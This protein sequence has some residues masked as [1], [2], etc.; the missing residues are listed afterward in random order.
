[1]ILKSPL[2]LLVQIMLLVVLAGAAQG[3]PIDRLQAFYKDVRTLRGDFTQ[4]VYDAHMKVKQRA[5]GTFAIR[6]PDRFHWAY[7][8]P[9]QQ[10]IVSDGTK[11]WIYDSDLQ[12]VTVKKLDEAL[13]STPAQLLSNSAALE[14]NFT[15]VDAGTAED[16]QWVALAPRDKDSGFERIRLGFDDKNLRSMV[17]EDNFGQTTRVEFSDLQRNLSLPDALF[18]FTP[19]PGVDVIGNEH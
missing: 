1:M 5:A 2:R 4:T 7:Q 8:K 6:R 19:P 11:V 15:L 13:G 18:Q 12:Q 16:L 10:L 3:G 9:Y 14:R 17:L